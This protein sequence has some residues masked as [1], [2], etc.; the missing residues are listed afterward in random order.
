MLKF[1]PVSQ[2]VYSLFTMFPITLKSSTYS[3]KKRGLRY[4]DLAENF[5]VKLLPDVGLGQVEEASRGCHLV[6]ASQNVCFL[7]H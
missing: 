5:G 6:S 4:S 1:K 3:Q 2:T 7:R